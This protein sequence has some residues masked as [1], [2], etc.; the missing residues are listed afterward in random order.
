MLGHTKNWMHDKGT[1]SQSVIDDL[2]TYHNLMKVEKKL[3]AKEW[4]KMKALGYQELYMETG[5]PNW[6]N[7]GRI[8]V[9]NLL[10]VGSN[11]LH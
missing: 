7:I 2:V 10:Q 9:C 1:H 3:T 11:F 5:K 6:T 8:L 4:T